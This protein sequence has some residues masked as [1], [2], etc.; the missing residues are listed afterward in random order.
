MRI[1]E[2]DAAFDDLAADPLASDLGDAI[3]H[4][5]AA[6]ASPFPMRQFASLADYEDR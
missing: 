5:I 3:P 4:R 6:L 2:Y 1:N